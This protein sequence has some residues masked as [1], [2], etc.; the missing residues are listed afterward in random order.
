MGAIDGV[1]RMDVTF[2]GSGAL[3][4]VTYTTSPGGPSGV[5]APA[6]LA[7]LGLG[8]VGLGLGQRRRQA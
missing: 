1:P 8:L 4:D 3:T 2:R 7:L 6:T 5:P